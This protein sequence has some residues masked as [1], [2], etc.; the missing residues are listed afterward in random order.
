MKRIIL[1]FVFVFLLVGCGEDG[2]YGESYGDS[3][4]DESELE[5][6]DEVEPSDEEVDLDDAE[7]TDETLGYSGNAS[8]AEFLTQQYDADG[9]A[10]VLVVDDG[11]RQET[12]VIGYASLEDHTPVQI[13]DRFRIGSVTKTFVGVIFVQLADE[14]VLSL[15]DPISQWLPESV[16]GQIENGDTATIRQLLSM[17]SGIF[18]Y[19]SSDAFWDRVA[20]NPTYGWTPEEVITF[21]YDEPATFE[22]GAGFEYSN[23]NYILLELIVQEA[24]GN[25]LATA[26]RTRILDP[27]NLEQ[28]YLEHAETLPNG[29]I[30]GYDYIDEDEEL[31]NALTLN[32][33]TGMGDGGLISTASDLATFMRAIYN[34]ELVSEAGY[35]AQY[36]MVDSGDG[37]GYGL[38]VSYAET[39]CGEQWGHDGST[40][41]FVSTV[42]YDVETDIVVVAMTNSVDSG[43]DADF[44]CE[45]VALWQ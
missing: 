14:G 31:D 18:D 17:S 22:A 1:I 44:V 13:T 40:A 41:G 2:E 42:W 33:G 10:V 32:D 38:G 16:W 21:A 5:P 28:T 7:E 36:D 23:S 26:L 29:H 30:A 8:L 6:R 9:P 45:V 15:D 4:E 25:D 3:Y 27:L 35:D 12:A 19:L 34:G 43:F 37:E 24:T 20:E 39:S 11:Q